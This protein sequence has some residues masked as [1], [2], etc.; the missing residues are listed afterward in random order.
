MRFL[1]LKRFSFFLTVLQEHGVV[2]GT[3]VLALLL[4]GILLFDGL[5]F[6]ARVI[7]AREATT[8]SERK[9]NLSEQEIADT[10]KLLDNREKKFNDILAGLDETGNATS[11]TKVR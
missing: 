5:I 11:S 7:R 8:D 4:A 1:N 6:Y 2:A 10:L 3:T 9:I